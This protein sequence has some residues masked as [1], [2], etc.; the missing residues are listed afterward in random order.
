MIQNKKEYLI[1]YNHDYEILSRKK[2]GKLHL[3]G[4]RNSI[5]LHVLAC[6]IFYIKFENV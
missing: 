5:K 6:Y 4:K 2:Q 1:V 3:K